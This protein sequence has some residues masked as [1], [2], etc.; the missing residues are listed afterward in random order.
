MSRTTRGGAGAL[1]GDEP[2]VGEVGEPPGQFAVGADGQPVH[3]AERDLAEDALQHGL[4][5]LA[6]REVIG[7][8]RTEGARWGRSTAS[9]VASA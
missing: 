4:P 1:S 7:D 3:V 5:E 6:V 2:L 9:T 8:V